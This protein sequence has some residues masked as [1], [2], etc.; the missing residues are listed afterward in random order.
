[1][2]ARVETKYAVVPTV[3]VVKYE[4]LG[5]FETYE[6]AQSYLS[7]YPGLLWT[8]EVKTLEK[9]VW[10]HSY[11]LEPVEETTSYYRA[12][13]MSRD[14]YV[15]EEVRSL[16]TVYVFDRCSPLG[17][18]MVLD[19]VEIAK[20][21][22][23]RML[24]TG[25]LAKGVDE[26]GEE[27]YYHSSQGPYSAR[28]YRTGV[29]QV[30]GSVVAWRIYR[31]IDTSHW[32]TRRTYRVV[33]PDGYEEGKVSIDELPSYA[34]GFPSRSDA[35]NAKSVVENMLGSW[36]DS[37]GVTLRFCEVESYEQNVSR[38]ETVTRQVKQ[39]YVTATFLKPVYDS[40]ELQPYHRVW[41]ETSYEEKWGWVFKGYVDEKPENYD[42]ST[43]VY[44]PEVVNWTS[45]TYLGIFTEWETQVLMSIDPRYVAEKHNTTTITREVSYYDVYNATWKLLYHYYKYVVH[46]THEYIANGNISTGAG[47]A[48]E[49]LGDANGEVCSSAFRSSPNSLRIVS[50]SGR[51]AWRQTFY[52]DAG[53]SSPV[54][55]FWYVLRG[56]GAVAVKKPDGSAQVFTLGENSG[57]TR[58]NRDSG[59]VFSQAGYYTISFVA[60]ENSELLVD[61]V[62][63]HVGGYGEWVYQ[64][65]VENRPEN[66]PSNEKYEAF[67]KIENKRLIGTFDESV[68]N[69]YPTPPYIKE[70]KKKETV[71]YTVDLYKLY[72]LEGGFVKYKVFHWEKTQVPIVVRKEESGAKWVKVET[73]VETGFGGLMLVEQNVPEDVVKAKYNDPVKYLLVP[74]VV[75]AGEALELVCETLD[76]SLAR[77]Y[78]KEG[79]IVRNTEVSTG[80]PIR[81]SIRMLQATVEK[82][83]MGM[84]GKQNTLRVAIAN[85]TQDTLAYQVTIEA[86]NNEIV[87]E[88]LPEG[89]AFHM[90]EAVRRITMVPVAEPSSWLLAV[91]PGGASYS[92][93]F[94]TWVRRTEEKEY[95]SYNVN[96]AYWPTGSVGCSF[97]V[98]VLRNGRLVAKQRVLETF[99]SF[100]V[101]RAIARH[102]FETVGGFLMGFGAMAAITALSFSLPQ[103]TIGLAGLSLTMSPFTLVGL[104]AGT[105]SALIVY[106]QTGSGVEALTYSPL[107]VLVA[108][109][110]A[111]ADPTMDDSRRASIIGAVIGAP[112]GVLV[113]QRIALDVAMLRMP[114]ELRND[115]EVYGFLYAAEKNYGTA[116]ASTVAGYIGK[117]YPYADVP[118]AKGLVALL[119][120]D[121]LKS[122]QDAFYIASMLEK[123]SGMGEEFL[124]RHAG[125][126]MEWL[127]S[128][129]LRYKLASLLQLSPDE[130]L[131]ISQSV[132]G[133]FVQMIR[134]AEFKHAWNQLSKLG[135]DT[136]RVLSWSPDG[137]EVGVEKS[138]AGKLYPG[139]QKGS[140]VEF[141]FARGS[142]VLK[143][144]LTYAEEKALGD[145][146]YLVFAFKAEERIPYVFDLL[147]EDMQAI[148]GQQAEKTFG[149]NAFNPSKGKLTLD[150]GSLSVD[151]SVRFS[152]GMVLKMDDPGVMLVPS[153]NPLETGTLNEVLLQ[154]R[155]SGTSVV[156]DED[157]VVKAFHQG[158]YLPAVVSASTLGLQLGI[159]AKPSGG[160]LTIPGESL[161]ARGILDPSLVHVVY[162]DGAAVT[163]LYTGG[164]LQIPLHSYF[165]GAF[166][167]VQ[168]VETRVVW[169]EAIGRREFYAQ[170][171]STSEI[172]GNALGI[173]FSEEFVETLL[174]S[175]LTDSQALDVANELV[176]NIEWLKAF[177][178]S[179]RIEAVR[180]IT[181][182]VVK[183]ETA[184]EAVEK[185]RRESEEYVR[186]LE[187]ETIEFYNSI[188]D[189]MLANEVLSLI[190]HIQERLGP[191]A[192]RWLLEVLKRTYVETLAST[193]GDREAADNRLRS[194]VEKAFKYPES[195]TQGCALSSAVVVEL[196]EKSV[197]EAWETLNRLVNYP[198]G[199]R[200]KCVLKPHEDRFTIHIPEEQ[201]ASYLGSEACWIRMEVKGT[202]L[203]KKYNPTF[204]FDVPPGLG[205]AGEEIEIT[206]R[207]ITPY[208][209]I[210][211]AITEGRM[212]FDIEFSLERYWLVVGD[213]KI[214]TSLKQGMYYDRGDKGPAVVFMIKDWQGEEHELKLVYN[215]DRKYL[216]KI[217]IE[218]FRQ[219]QDAEYDSETG[220]L[221]ITY[222]KGDHAS[223]HLIYLENPKSVLT[224]MV[225]KLKITL[226][227]ERE[228]TNLEGDIGEYYI[229]LYKSDVIKEKVSEILGVPKDKIKVVKGYSNWGP[230]FY[231]YC[232][233]KLV[234]IIDVKTTTKSKYYPAEKLKEAKDSLE[235][236]YFTRDEWKDLFKKVKYGIPIAVFLKNLDE[237]IQTEFL[238]GIDCKLGE[239]VE[240]PN[241]EP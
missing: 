144:F 234:A 55:D 61:D 9:Q 153:E 102:P 166:L 119:L 157:G 216:S 239:V 228:D 87:E 187:L 125:S 140:V 45:K 53:G 241:Y 223:E 5:E 70:F 96:T 138:L 18:L 90:P 60:S 161:R 56:S 116:F 78:E 10:V 203:Y 179:R 82:N 207:K 139:I 123:A 24:Q 58:F 186:N 191:E 171:A 192:A 36:A 111:L 107:G 149:F 213:G 145:S 114:S 197:E 95:G 183:G 131:Q 160:A 182:Y 209:F 51:G 112:L 71:S 163:T 72:Y 40:Y 69:Q 121:A 143:G 7:L 104:A 12:L 77:K 42:A 184:E 79:Y 165:S 198:D 21:V 162:P 210:R 15:A 113:G 202:V 146:K 127:G 215:W 129:L 217:M 31:R 208:E 185:V 194:V 231:V 57:W 35:E 195:V 232:E 218:D 89:Q 34:K 156:V 110:R 168:T 126:V 66:V 167:G 190:K 199:L 212:P 48:F 16:V 137:I 240:N 128:P 47:W 225:E 92:L 219:I 14:G 204:N 237:I 106:A 1:E 118:D 32:E 80:N 150:K 33:A 81:F 26:H 130:A 230:D 99:D 76:G 227:E 30:E 2:A 43:W 73:G 98:K 229:M 176:R 175:G 49:N 54:L 120:S 154:G 188:P 68:A 135:P 226:S 211:T 59:D 62:S 122:R 238:S 105:A 38:V 20:E 200:V 159:L 178:S 22:F 25:E 83:E 4:V 224:R 124:R 52:Y 193:L 84:L 93:E 147:R 196:M 88:M 233:G 63:L 23:E 158:D 41:N 50:G 19:R 85:P 235:N 6:A 151:G 100:N 141:E 117:L 220:I 170:V 17:R 91:Q 97:T 64:G 39:Y 109:V 46:P 11:R 189:T 8:A 29:K 173:A 174:L 177:S 206:I 44:S 181:E 136:V 222:L 103:V 115:P 169:T 221:T 132:G 164:S 101:E 94:A 205:E 155:I 180:R 108:P 75:D 13:M 3:R 27:Y 37:Q 74:K 214:E 134:L 28:L 152:D 86:E 236:K 201:L 65:D 148:P 172:I 142:I 67:Y 133:D